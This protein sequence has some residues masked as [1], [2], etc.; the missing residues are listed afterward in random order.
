MSHTHSPHLPPFLNFPGPTS[1]HSHHLN[2]IMKP[3]KIVV[4]LTGRFA[5]CKA[6]I[7]KVLESS[8][9]RKAKGSKARNQAIVCGLEVAPKR[10]TKKYLK[11]VEKMTGDEKAKSEKR[12]EN[13]QQVKTFV[14]LVNFA[15]VMPTRYN[16][17]LHEELA[18]QV[19][20]EESI[21]AEV[22]KTLKDS[23]KA[24]LEQ[25]Y[26]AL[27]SMTD[28]KAQKHTLYFFK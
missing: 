4:M 14:K 17:D 16:I 11:T 21:K 3:G 23:F 2:R 22:R 25:H 19:S 10:V 18:K 1:L 8:D 15:H 28:A 27:G 9:D 20:G 12:V 5:G 26:K 24:K 6:V 13:K 7:L